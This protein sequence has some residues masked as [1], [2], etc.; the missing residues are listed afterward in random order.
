MPTAKAKPKLPSAEQ[1]ADDTFDI[2]Y[3]KDL[4]KHRKKLLQ[5][6]SKKA[7]PRKVLYPS[8]EAFVCADSSM[9]CADSTSVAV[10][11]EQKKAYPIM[12]RDP[13]S[14]DE[15]KL[16][17][18][19][20]TEEEAAAKAVEKNPKLKKAQVVFGDD[21]LTKDYAGNKVRCGNVVD[22]RPLN[23]NVCNGYQQDILTRKWA[24]PLNMPGE[25]INGEAFILGRTGKVISGQKRGVAFV[26]AVEQ[27]RAQ[28]ATWETVWPTEP[29]FECL[30]IRGASEAQE[31]V[32]T[33]DNTQARSLADTI[34]TSEIFA[35]LDQK[36]RLTCSKMLDTAIDFLWRRTGAEK[37]NGIKVYQTHSASFDFLGRHKRLEECVKHIFEE[38]QEKHLSN[39]DLAAGHCAAMLYLMGS[40]ETDGDSYRNADPR[41]EEVV[42]WEF[43]EQAQEF[44]V[45]LAGSDSSM[46]PVKAAILALPTDPEGLQGNVTERIAILAKAWGLVSRAEKITKEELALEYGKN[47]LGATVLVDPPDFGGIDVGPDRQS[48]AVDPPPPTEA[49]I[50]EAQE[51][52]RRLRAEEDAAKVKKLKNKPASMTNVAA[53]GEGKPA[54]PKLLPTPA[55]KR[56]NLN[57]A[58]KS[59][60]ANKKG[61]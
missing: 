22:N 14:Y 27:W 46:V 37:Q 33:I 16:I 52:A 55:N 19:W 23:E 20:E 10:E 60:P 58:P 6:K 15:M 28:K 7:P 44:W 39:L 51:E 49:Q 48:E 56:E 36:G 40:C 8:F 9:P 1:L 24:G 32:E 4:N 59:Q 34:S 13:L 11:G 47:L 31:I 25:T 50:K 61:K 35:G 54:A 41:S 57:A 42:N 21:H 43:W 26:R 53:P 17:L 38:N 3:D 18:G 30:I 45:L 12:R 2:V 29:V 5:P